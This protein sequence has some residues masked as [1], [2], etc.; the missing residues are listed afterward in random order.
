ML[1]AFL[2]AA[3]LT[4]PAAKL[5]AGETFVSAAVVQV[6][7][8]RTVT[9]AWDANPA[10]DNVTTYRLHRGTTPG[11]Y[12][13]HTDVGTVTQTTTPVLPAGAYYF[14]VTAVNPIGESAKSN[15][16]AAAVT[17]TSAPD[18]APP[19]GAQAIAVFITKLLP[20][21]SGAVGSKATLYFQVA[22]PGAS[23]TSIT[24]LVNGTVA[25][26]P[27]T[28]DDAG[29]IWFVTPPDPGTYPVS[30]LVV[31]AAGCSTTATKDA[32]GHQ[33]TVTVK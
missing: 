33:L 21:P 28:G 32:L 12:T 19:L 18:C 26:K 8:P 23:V 24:A 1:S 25:S 4:S 17:A 5:P 11:S 10:S 9:L 20:N 7:D 30:L 31:N 13:V 22:S 27:L 14:A 3:F 15:E 29:G 6:A 2:L 16:A